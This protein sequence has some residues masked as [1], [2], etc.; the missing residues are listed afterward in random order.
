MVLAINDVL[1][2]IFHMQMATTIWTVHCTLSAP[3]TSTT[4][5]TWKF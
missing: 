3:I 1:F 5:V 4:V 2:E